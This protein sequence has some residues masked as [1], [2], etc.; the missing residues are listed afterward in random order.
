MFSVQRIKFSEL[1]IKK[2]FEFQWGWNAMLEHFLFFQRL[3]VTM[4]KHPSCYK[5]NEPL[6]SRNEQVKSEAVVLY[7][8]K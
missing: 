3:K 4:K 2:I 7:D 6:K 5:L 1:H 8:G